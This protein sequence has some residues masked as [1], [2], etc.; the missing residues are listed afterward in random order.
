MFKDLFIFILSIGE[1][2]LMCMCVRECICQ[3][4]ASTEARKEHQIL[5]NWNYGWLYVSMWVFGTKLGP[6]ER[7]A[8]ALIHRVSSPDFT[9]V[10]IWFSL[11]L[12]LGIWVLNLY[13][14]WLYVCIWLIAAPAA[15]SSFLRSARNQSSTLWVWGNRHSITTYF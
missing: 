14:V 7:A 4:K 6:S 12:L 8:N 3:H 9:P 5:Q 13:L 1:F 10:C 2:C 11:L 15:N